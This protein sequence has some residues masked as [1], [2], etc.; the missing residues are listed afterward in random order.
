VSRKGQR[1]WSYRH[2]VWVAL[3]LQKRRRQAAAN[4][5]GLLQTEGGE[6]LL[7][8]DG[9]TLAAKGSA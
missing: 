6:W 7:T 9:R 4:A 1:R 8:E 2:R 3:L 5:V